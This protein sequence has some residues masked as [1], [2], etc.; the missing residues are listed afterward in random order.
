MEAE[1]ER[2]RQFQ[3]AEFEC[4]KAILTAMKKAA[5]AETKLKAIKQAIEEGKAEQ[6]TL[7]TIS[8]LYEPTDTKQQTQAAFCNCLSR[9]LLCIIHHGH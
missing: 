4:D 3:R 7:T 5:I 9:W 2:K 8:H 6:D 1:E